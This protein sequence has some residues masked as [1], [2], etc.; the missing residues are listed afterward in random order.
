[1][2]DTSFDRILLNKIFLMI[3]IQQYRSEACLPTLLN[4]RI[5]FLGHNFRLRYNFPRPLNHFKVPGQIPHYQRPLRPT[6][7]FYSHSVYQRF[8]KKI[9]QN[10]YF[11]LSVGISRKLEILL[12]NLD[13]PSSSS[14]NASTV[15]ANLL[16]FNKKSTLY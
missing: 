1:M 7:F 9:K 16:I 12:I 2:T 13:Y 6:E 5:H 11:N 15:I 4:S 8:L 14:K 10:L 3:Q